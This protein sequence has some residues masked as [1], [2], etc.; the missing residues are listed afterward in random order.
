MNPEPATYLVRR[1]RTAGAATA[2]LLDELTSSWREAC[3]AAD[4]IPW[5]VFGGLL[6]LRTDELILVAARCPGSLAWPTLTDVQPIEEF[7]GTPTARPLAPIPQETPGIYV[8]RQFEISATDVDEFVRL[9]AEAWESFE[10]DADY[11]AEPRALLRGHASEGATRMLLV[12]WYDHLASWERSRQPP[13][14]ARANF[15]AR[16]R[17]TRWALP[18][19]TRLVQPPA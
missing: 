14:A 10:S 4:A 19:A 8:F 12:T 11:R 16:A 17:L 7:V 3:L 9:S 5:G 1:V 6:G 18:I 2:A 15:L 13:A